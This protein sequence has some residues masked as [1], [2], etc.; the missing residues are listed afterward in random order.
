MGTSNSSH[1]LGQGCL[2]AALKSFT[3]FPDIDFGANSVNNLTVNSGQSDGYWTNQSLDLS[4][5]FLTLFVIGNFN[6][7]K[8]ICLFSHLQMRVR[9]YCD[10]WEKGRTVSDLLCSLFEKM[11]FSRLL[12]SSYA[13]PLKLEKKIARLLQYVQSGWFVGNDIFCHFASINYHSGF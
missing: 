7:F 9:V 10:V 3:T 4:N 6:T 12:I 8:N 5:K 13:S 11:S 2:F 1:G